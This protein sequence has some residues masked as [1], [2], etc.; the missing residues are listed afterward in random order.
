MKIAIIYHSETGNTKEIAEIIGEGVN[1]LDGVE[2]KCMSITDVDDEFINDSK[3][4][5]LG[6]PTYYG[7]F[8]WQIK[9]WFD[10]YKGCK[11]NDKLGATFA[12][13][14]FLGGGADF[15]LLTL[16]GHML[17]RGMV[18]YSGGAAEGKPFTHF[19]AVAIKNGD[20]EQRNRARIF[21]LRVAK[22][23]IELYK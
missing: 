18:V 16:V 21:G 4:V 9:K 17:V 22:K 6:C 5:I 7:D 23:T 15:A 8:S 12:T 13:E 10:E 20:E 14:N 11:L 19:G 2:Y 1:E 3:A